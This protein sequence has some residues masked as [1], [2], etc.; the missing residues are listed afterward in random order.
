MNMNDTP[1]KA[2]ATCAVPVELAALK[3]GVY[4]PTCVPAEA[5][6]VK[7]EWR[8]DTGDENYLHINGDEC[9]VSVHPDH[10]DRPVVWYATVDIYTEGWAENENTAKANG[11]REIVNRIEK[12]LAAAKEALHNETGE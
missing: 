9:S 5:L 10:P 8:D 3:G 12:L 1:T 6:I 11:L 4:C 7:N 2:C